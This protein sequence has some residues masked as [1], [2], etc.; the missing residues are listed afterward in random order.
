MSGPLLKEHCKALK[1]AYVP[2]CY[3]DIPYRDKEQYLTDLFG[4]ELRA[5][6]THKVRRLIKRAGFLSTKT[7]E[8]F[9]WSPVTFQPP[10]T[11]ADLLNLAF[12]ARN[13]NVLALG[14]VDPTT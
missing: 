14:A 11:Q 1:L 8:D 4:E 7:L 10:T 9:D 3:D 13:E 5:R 6:Q 2:V 12:L